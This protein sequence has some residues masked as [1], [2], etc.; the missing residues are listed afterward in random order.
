MSLPVHPV[1]AQ[2]IDH[3]SRCK[4]LESRDQYRTCHVHVPDSEKRLAAIVVNDRYYSFFKL[5][6]DSQKALQTAAK[7]VYRG[8]EVA[9]TRTVKGDAIW[10]YEPE[11]RET[12]ATPLTSHRVAA[13]NSGLW[14][15]LDSECEYRP[16]Q[17]RVPDVAKPMAAIYSDR[18]Y[19][20]HLRTVR[21]QTQA[22]ELAERLSGKGHAARITK[23]ELA[24]AIW[25]LESEASIQA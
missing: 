24:W 4:F 18:Q 9:T 2:S 21:E 19:F 17:I 20:S 13:S 1:S 16:C 8:D 23:H 14:K 7:L 22:I 6:K 10:I 25:V 11:A 12:K 3:L 15:I 5:V